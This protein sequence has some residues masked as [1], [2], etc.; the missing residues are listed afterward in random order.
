MKGETKVFDY[1]KLTGRVIEKFGSRKA[2]AKAYGIS[3]NA[4]SRKLRGKNGI[5]INDIVRMSQPEFLDIEAKDF[6]AYF[7]T[8]K[9]QED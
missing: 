7:F 4:M 1:S 6:P 2:F 5:T 9:V 8:Q 3:E